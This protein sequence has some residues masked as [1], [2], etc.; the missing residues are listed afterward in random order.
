MYIICC[1]VMSCR[2]YELMHTIFC[3]FMSCKVYVLMYIIFSE[4]FRVKYVNL[5]QIVQLCILY[6]NSNRRYCW[7]K[8][9]FYCVLYHVDCSHSIVLLLLTPFWHLTLSSHANSQL[10]RQIDRVSFENR[11]VKTKR[12]FLPF[13]DLMSGARISIPRLCKGSYAV[14]SFSFFV[15]LRRGN[16]FFTHSENFREFAGNDASLCGQY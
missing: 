10:R 7:V 8:V 16:L 4:L 5:G 3:Q 12:N 15:L 14:K 2:V 9:Y 6:A 13:L 1:Q 11:S